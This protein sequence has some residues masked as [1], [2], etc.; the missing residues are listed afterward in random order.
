MLQQRAAIGDIEGT[1]REKQRAGSNVRMCT[2][3]S[4][5]SQRASKTGES[6]G[7]GHR[8]S[9]SRVEQDHSS[10]CSCYAG[11]PYNNF[12]LAEPAMRQRTSLA[13]FS[14]V[15]SSCLTA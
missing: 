1:F 6:A 13:P 12:P 2:L 10:D 7:C 8:C 15:Q 9:H 11:W 3:T 5:S 14:G 4:S